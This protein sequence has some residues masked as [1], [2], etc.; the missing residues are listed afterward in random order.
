MCLVLHGADL[1][2]PPSAIHADIGTGI[3]T[4]IGIGIGIG[5]DATQAQLDHL[6]LRCTWLPVAD[7]H[8]IQIQ[9][10]QMQQMGDSSTGNG[11]VLGADSQSTNEY[12]APVPAQPT[13]PPQP[14]APTPV[15]AT[16]TEAAVAV[17]AVAAQSLPSN[18]WEMR[19]WVGLMEAE[20]DVDDFQVNYVIVFLSYHLTILL[21]YCLLIFYSITVFLS[22]Y[23]IIILSYI[24]ALP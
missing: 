5:V 24:M 6:G 7:V 8:L 10:M 21:S 1:P 11:R 13:L 22:Y 18:A 2:L 4:G 17:A 20:I 3:G 16:A 19:L 12:N 14:P 23:H 9:Q 15:T